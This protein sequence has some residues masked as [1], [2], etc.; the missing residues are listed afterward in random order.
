[1]RRSLYTYMD[2]QPTSTQLHTIYLLETGHSRTRLPFEMLPAQRLEASGQVCSS[3]D[4]LDIRERPPDRCVMQEG[5][6]SRRSPGC[7]A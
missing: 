6:L 4:P 5:R 3:A 1:M 2:P 7:P